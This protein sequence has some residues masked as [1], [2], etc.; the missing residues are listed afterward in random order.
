MTHI[1]YCADQQ[2]DT[3]IVIQYDINSYHTLLTLPLAEIAF[4]L[5]YS[6]C[7]QMLNFSGAQ[8]GKSVTLKWDRKTGTSVGVL[9][10]PGQIINYRR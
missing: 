8:L 2:V 5:E 9:G 1:R 10:L 4:S 3:T 6:V 7:Y